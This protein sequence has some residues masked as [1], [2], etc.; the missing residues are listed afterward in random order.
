MASL[1]SQMNL[2][3]VCYNRLFLANTAKD[4]SLRQL[5]QGQR[6]AM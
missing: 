6:N 5:L 2:Y 3:Q 4:R 1:I